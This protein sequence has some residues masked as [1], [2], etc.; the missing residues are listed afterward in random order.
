M[1]CHAKARFF[2]SWITAC[3]SLIH[4][5]ACGIFS[6]SAIWKIVS[7]PARCLHFHRINDRNTVNDSFYTLIP[8]THPPHIVA[9]TAVYMIC[10]MNNID[11]VDAFTEF[12]FD[13][14]EIYGICSTMC[15]FYEKGV[16]LWPKEL[17][18][19]ILTISQQF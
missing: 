18:D 8:I 10:T 6:P 12:K 16:D 11:P 3:C 9:A 19:C 15:A 5:D 4:S 1:C 14:R 13:M 2:Q 17:T 7:K